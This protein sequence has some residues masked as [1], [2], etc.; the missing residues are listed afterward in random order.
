M[1]LFRSTMFGMS[2]FAVCAGIVAAVGLFGR[3][4]I[5]QESEVATCLKACRDGAMVCNTPVRSDRKGCATGCRDVMK[6]ALVEC[7]T[8]ADPATSLGDAFAAAESCHSGCAGVAEAGHDTCFA[9]TND[10]ILAC[11][12]EQGQCIVGC[13]EAMR[14]C[15]Q[16]AADKARTCKDSCRDSMVTTLQG[17]TSSEDGR[18]CAQAARA[19]AKE[20]KAPCVEALTNAAGDCKGTAKIC[21][22]ACRS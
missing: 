17:C 18:V 15:R 22:E 6:K 5:A 13:R 14:E 9:S 4:A 21:K 8:A 20:C 2:W 11:T 3:P 16:S 19:K 1:K 10:C 7:K 12:S